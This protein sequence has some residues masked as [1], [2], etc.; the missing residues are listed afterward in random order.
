MNPG[1]NH[2]QRLLILFL[3]V[4]F[5]LTVHFPLNAQEAIKKIFN[6]Q[7]ERFDMLQNEIPFEVI[8]NIPQRHHIA[9]RGEKEMLQ[10]DP[11][12]TRK[13]LQTP[14]T[15]LKL[16]IPRS[17]NP[18][19]E[20]HLKEVNILTEE[21]ILT[22]GQNQLVHPS[23]NKAKFYWGYVNGIDN[24]LA[25]IN[26][27]KNEISGSIDIGENTFTL[28]KD[29]KS[30]YYMMYKEDDIVEQTSFSCFAEEVEHA[31]QRDRQQR[32]ERS[33]AN[34]N[35]CVRMYLEVDN[36]LYNHFGNMSDTY[37]YVVGAMSQVA[38][39]Y[40]NEAINFSINQMKI[41]DTA[42][43]YNGS[44]TSEFL[45]AFRNN[46]G[47]NFEG[48]L[49]HL[50]GTAGSGGIAY[51]DVLCF[52]S[53]GHGYS[54]IHTTYSDVPAYSWTVECLTHEIGHNLGSQH[55]HDCVW[56]ENNTP[57]DGCGPAAGYD[58]ET[59]NQNAAIPPS[60][61]IM[62]YCHLVSGVGIDFNLGFGP[63]PGDLVRDRVY[64]SSCLTSCVECNE[65]GNPCDDGN[66]CTINDAIDSYCN[67]TGEPV[68]DND[69]DGY[70][71][72]TDPDDNNFCNPDPG[73]N[74][75]GLIISITTDNFPQ[76]TSWELLDDQGIV[77]HSGGNYTGGNTTY[78]YRL[79]LEDGCYEFLIY[80]SY[81]DGICCQ[82]GQGSY[83][84]MDGA[85]NILASGGAFTNSESAT[86]C[87]DN[88]TQCIA[89][90][91]C[92]DGDPCT[93]D[94][95]YDANCNCAGTFADLDDD[96]I[97]DSNDPCYDP[98]MLYVD[99][100]MNEGTY[101]ARSEIVLM[102][103][104]SLPS[105][106]IMYLKAPVIRISEDIIIPENTMIITSSQPCSN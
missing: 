14:S 83:Q 97:C 93:I 78:I 53:Y 79:C 37:N 63:Q 74:T 102:P 69:E 56:N 29:R 92:D 86:F 6:G 32:T 5:S 62:S 11:E 72:L 87:Y 33:V 3:C 45:T 85:G 82:Y 42:D 96:G 100:V 8:A 41:W 20:L 18:P 30:P 81:G 1:C 2:N 105:N 73:G 12:F 58:V 94:D 13:I 38:V 60:G 49:A 80:D 103:G 16:D 68:A 66:P 28:A 40:A 90:N 64:T 88:Y 7:E 54:G 61:T 71:E 91:P 43:P 50:I 36:D 55:T 47:S 4:I 57:I 75:S 95:V 65:I 25:V 17:G 24:S 31:F 52:K 27:F 46:I 39:L 22:N 77:L 26:V 70:C 10:I 9:I 59:C 23:E 89:G 34:E 76:E 98:M 44:T 21:F 101:H 106:A 35:N 19:L 48:D 15:F 99:N 84:V 51:R 67:C 104:T